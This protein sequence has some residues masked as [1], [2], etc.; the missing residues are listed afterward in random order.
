MGNAL[1]S[2]AVLIAEFLYVHRKAGSENGQKRL[3]SQT[4]AS[5]KCPLKP[6]LTR[7][8]TDASFL[9]IYG[10]NKSFFFFFK[11]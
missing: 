10:I 7:E 3:Q 1:H 4:D 5:R 8:K 6:G 11:F 2:I 9:R